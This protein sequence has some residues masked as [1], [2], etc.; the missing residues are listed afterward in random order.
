MKIGFDAKRA[1]QNNT[2]L[3]NYSR[4]MVEILSGLDLH[5]S[6]ILFAPK[7]KENAQLAKIRLR[8]SVSFI[9]P[10]KLLSK[11]L[12][13]FWRMFWI[14]SDLKKEK[15][16][17]YHGLSN[18]LPVGIRKTGVKSIVTIHDLIF[19]RYPHYY[20]PVD[21]FIY[22]LKFQHACRRA[23]KIVAI[24]ECT[25]RDIISFFNI[26][27]E[28]IQVIYQGCHPVF[29]EKVTSER[30]HAVA[31]K[32]GLPPHFLLYVGSIEPRKNLLLAVKALRLVSPEIHLVAIGKWTPYQA[33]VEEFAS[34]HGLSARLHIFNGITFEELPAF[35][36]LS[37]IFVYP[38]IFEGFG[39]PIVEALSQ[40]I[41][42]IA[43]T[44]SCLEEAGGPSS[45]YVDPFD[46][47][48][49][50]DHIADLWNNPKRIAEMSLAG[51]E[52]VRNFDERAIAQELIA[53][54][55]STL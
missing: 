37:K 42:V 15:I 12:P 43:T 23:D 5:H 27:E 36:A 1:V 14:K 51:K 49:L 9:F 21:R 25:K 4:Y 48:A 6:Y 19:L 41:P 13:S 29:H 46:E 50:A 40:G 45:I 30:K 32:Y 28:K 33:T 31:D 38:S 24:S 39:I 10:T 20:K 26:P 3:G 22:R 53:L 44:G 47:K 18:E 17:I 16:D 7:K 34:S 2:G 8:P 55:I 52:F 11:I 54:Y 35:Y